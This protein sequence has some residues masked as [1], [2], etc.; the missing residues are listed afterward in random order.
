LVTCKDF[1]NELSDYLDDSVQGD[2]RAEL[3]KHLSECPN[4][5]VICDTTRKTIEIYRGTEV[6]PVPPEVHE[7][8]LAAV[9]KKAAVS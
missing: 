4:C 8:L 9:R 5:Y 2:I 1:L 3:E 6:L 7:R